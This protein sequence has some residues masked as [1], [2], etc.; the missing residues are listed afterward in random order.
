MEQ[1]IKNIKDADSYRK[2]AGYY[3]ELIG[4]HYYNNLYNVFKNFTKHFPAQTRHLDIGCGT[5]YLIKKSRDLNFS[6]EGIDISK[7]MIEIAKNNN[8]GINIYHGNFMNITKYFN[9]L[10]ICNKY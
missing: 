9:F 5:G 1:I 7:E 8:P 3:D 6:P 10:I 2:L 4:K